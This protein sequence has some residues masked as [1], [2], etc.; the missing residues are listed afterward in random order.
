MGRRAELVLRGHDGVL[1]LVVD[2]RLGI[3]RGGRSEVIR[4]PRVLG[5]GLTSET[6]FLQGGRRS[7]GIGRSSSTVPRAAVP[8]SGGVGVLGDGLSE[9]TLLGA[10]GR[11]TGGGRVRRSLS[12]PAVHQAL[13][14]KDTVQC[15]QL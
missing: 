5:A 2:L 3:G 6:A 9:P 10:V 13:K 12:K 4:I 1:L 14:K 8:L 7:S 15:T 11:R